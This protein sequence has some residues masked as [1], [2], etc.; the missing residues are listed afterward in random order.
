MEVHPL[1]I[2]GQWHAGTGGHFDSINPADGSVSAR[3]SH[4]SAADVGAAVAAARAALDNPAWSR[5]KPHERAALLAAFASAV[6]RARD[7]LARAQMTD[8]GKTLAEC[9][10]QATEA[11]RIIRY[12][13]AL[14]E[15][16]EGQ[17]TPQRGPALT[18]TLYE[19]M[20]VVA[21][22]TPWNSPLTIEAQ[23]L[24]PILAAGNTVVLKPSEVTPQVAL[25]FGRLALEAGIPPGVVNVVTG[26]GDTGR[27]LVEHPG[28]DMISFT[29]GTAAGR[30]IAATAGAR[31]RPV[32][33]ELGGKSP[34]MVFADADLEAAARG[35]AA[36]IFGSGGQSCIAG[37]RILVEA[38][39]HDAFLE[40]LVAEGARY[41]TGPPEDP[42]SVIG[43]M[44][45]FGH[46]DA[47]VTAV[48]A[49]RAEG[50]GVALGGTP[51][52][53]PDLAAGAYF[54][55]TLLTGL[56]NRA[57]TSQTEIFGPVGVVLPFRD[58]AD[59]LAQAND[60]D[61]GLAAGIWTED[62]RRAWR[63]GRAVRA[64]TVWVNTYKQSS[65]S[66]PFGGVKDSGLGRE[67][68][69]AGLRAYSQPKGL[70]W[71]LD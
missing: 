48:A 16:A 26:L 28:V 18:M 46:R 64:G 65:I 37:S 71:Q 62:S 36:G 58:E 47:V 69:L 44:A 43:P 3:I 53:D 25:V 22:I 19:P 15:T 70:H 5:I 20:G 55:P 39:I 66:T 27:A 50:A 56:T 60:T 42:A 4:A 45:S 2:G 49:A 17:L 35:V 13:A 9:T 31:L 68:G 38:A 1:L 14:C 59:L 11:A 61:F 51:P 63:V 6:D 67:K 33:L 12:Y 32:L 34:N 23:K 10:A 41:R 8:N 7:E 40:R 54:L 52:A 21:A 24:A 30:H 57:R 29:G